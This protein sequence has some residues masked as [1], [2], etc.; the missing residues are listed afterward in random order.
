[1]KTGGKRAAITGATKGIGR[2]LVERFAA[3]GFDV[4]FCARTPG[5]VAALARDLAARYPRQRF[6]GHPA[7]LSTEEGVES[8]AKAVLDEP[9]GMDVLVNNAGVYKPCPLG[10]PAGREAFDLMLR[11]NV[12][13]AYLLTLR[14]LPS[15]RAARRGHIFNICSI[16]SLIPYGGGYSVSKFALLGFS[17]NLRDELKNEGIRVTAVLPGAVLTPA[18][19]GVKQPAERFIRAEDVAEAVWSCHALSPQTVVEELLL[20]PQQ[21]DF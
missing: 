2:A 12:H 13:S 20:R 21:G 6:L 9:Q 11:T 14:V 18:W 10:D 19:D 7:D 5:D 16:A 17:K 4:A 3:G 1:M 15:M 8:F